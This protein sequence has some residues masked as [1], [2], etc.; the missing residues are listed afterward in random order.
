MKT[1]KAIQVLRD[2]NL[3]RRGNEEMEQPDQHTIGEAIDDILMAIGDME[4]EAELY[5]GTINGWEDK[6]KCAV[7]LAA[8]ARADLD[9]ERKEGE[10]QARL[11]GMSAEREAKLIAERDLWRAEAQR[12]REQ[13]M[14]L[15]GQIE[16]EI[17]RL[18]WRQHQLDRGIKEL[19]GD[20]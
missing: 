14:E 18:Q 3:W 11:L 1:E 20:Y 13:V 16:T 19:K 4:M 7:E 5:R 8:N 6:W 17:Q 15:E 9:E 12:W 2:F 10:E